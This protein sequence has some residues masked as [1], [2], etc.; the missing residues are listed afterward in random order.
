MY[1]PGSRSSRLGRGVLLRIFACHNYLSTFVH[2]QTPKIWRIFSNL[3][4][5]CILYNHLQNGYIQSCLSLFRQSLRDEVFVVCEL[6]S[7]VH[8]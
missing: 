5:R 4:N 1:T 6:S 8:T 7:A 2:R 3:K